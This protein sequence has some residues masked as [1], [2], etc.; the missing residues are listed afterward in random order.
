MV[1][2]SSDLLKP[3]KRVKRY[4]N[5]INFYVNFVQI[6]SF[7][8]AGDPIKGWMWWNSGKDTIISADGYS[9][10]HCNKY[11]LHF[12]CRNL[13]QEPGASIFYT[14]RILNHNLLE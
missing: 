3:T 4:K 14:S 6:S 11:K 12:D 8:T 2:N 13:F 7:I 1:Y 9:T 10:R 5:I